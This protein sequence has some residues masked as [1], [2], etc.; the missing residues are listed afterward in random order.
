MRFYWEGEG[1]EGTGAARS[2]GEGTG[3]ATHKGQ[4]ED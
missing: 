2:P 3:Q 4:R 1:G